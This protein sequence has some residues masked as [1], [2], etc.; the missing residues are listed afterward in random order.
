MAFFLIKWEWMFIPGAAFLLTGA[1]LWGYWNCDRDSQRRMASGLVG[2]LGGGALG[3]AGTLLQSSVSGLFA[4]SG[5]NPASSG[6]NPQGGQGG[7]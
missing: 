6:P 3:M 2:G 4:Q 5:N 7:R 1:N